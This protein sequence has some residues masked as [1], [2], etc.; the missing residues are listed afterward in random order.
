MLSALIRFSV[1]R[2]WV[3]LMG[4]LVLLGYGA[5]R[6]SA[7][8]LDIFPEFS[9]R[10]VVVQTEAPGYAAE[11]VE[12]LVTAPI[13][14]SLRG[15]IGLDHVRSESIQGLSIV[16][17]VFDDGTSN[18]TNR[19]QVSERLAAVRDLLPVGVVDPVPVPLSSSSATVRTV[20]VRAPDMDPIALRRIVEKTLV[21]RFMA[22]RGVA[23]VNVFGGAEQA[24]EISPD[25]A[26]MARMGVGLNGVMAAAQAA[27]TRAGA[28]FL[29]G[30]NQRFTLLTDGAALSPAALAA[31]VVRA[32][33]RGI[34]TLGDVADVSYA[35]L[36]GF[37]AA[38]I[39]GEPGI[40]MMIIGQFGAN[41]YTVSGRLERVLDDLGP[42]L[43]AQGVDLFPSLFVP[44]RYIERSL[45]D[46]TSH[47]GIGA[48]M[49]LVV[50]FLGLYNVRTALISAVAIPLSLTAALLILVESGVNLNVMVLAG[51]AIALGEVVDDAVID[52]E[53]IFRRLR[54]RAAGTDARAVVTGASLE[55]RSSVVYA[56]FIVAL[57]F[58]PLLTL[59]GVSGRLFAPL[60]SAYILSVLASL[61]VAVT[62][63]PALCMLLLTRT[64]LRSTEA[65]FFRFINPP[66]E[67][68]LS[69]L[70]RHAR[71]T[72]LATV[73]ISLVIAGL[74][75]LFGERFL[76]ELREGH[77]ILH[78]TGL[79]GTSIEESIRVGTQ[80]TRAVAQIDGVVSVSQ[81]AGRA[82]RG[83][84]TY[85]S[86]YSEYD[87]ALA[88]LG[89]PEQQA[90]LD[91]IIGILASLPGVTFEANTFLTERVDETI[92]GYSAPVVVNIFGDDLDILDRV[93]AE[94]AAV[95]RTTPG[96]TNVRVRS[97]HGRPVFEVRFDYGALARYGISSGD[98]RQALQALYGG[99]QVGEV[100]QDGRTY[101]VMV[102]AARDDRV[103]PELLAQ[104]PLTTAAGD[105]V[106][107][108][109]IAEVVPGAGRYN[110][111]HRD[112][113]RLQVVT[114]GVADGDVAGFVARLKA[115][116]LADVAL[117]AGVVTE[118]TGAATEQ[119]GARN[120]LIL[121]SLV[122]GSAV[123]LLIFM[124]VGSA[125]HVGIIMLN[126]PFSFVGGVLAVALTGG[127]ISIGSVVGFVTL[128]GIT[129]RNS[130]MLVSHYS[131]LVEVD[132][133][134][135]NLETAVLGA[136][137][138]LPAILMTA[139][140]TALAMLPL[141]VNS[142]NPGREIMG[143]MAG[144][145][146][147]GLASSTLLNLFV[148]PVVFARYGRFTAPSDR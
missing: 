138:R 135:W 42:I 112:A 25:L 125:R 63:T 117:P 74:V 148:M 36:P 106:P 10:L 56:T 91:Q 67:R 95:A 118:F 30:P 23:D 57:V 40:I 100:V 22:V 124:A 39:G 16:T 122:A 116:V 126:L 140:V 120:Q 68:A 26:A 29:E 143:P 110:I 47:L 142:D 93:A 53:N 77:Y 3:V 50:L 131:H 137:E 89:G 107:L 104:M 73:A 55:V 37:S 20:G 15:L 133:R 24:L 105:V 78:T 75:P 64:R 81:W 8:G 109:A 97:V 102:L 28:G 54:Q 101:P 49:V 94:V 84:D 5:A 70:M 83:A 65:P 121:D 139:L 18:Y 38:Q 128:F 2:P 17:A 80:L 134:P 111:V 4:A 7:A 13:E 52:T 127:V 136:R 82:E 144:I 33:P 32:D 123:L 69:G 6:I 43:A 99:A 45:R 145:I 41:T 58:V 35:A 132:G 88:P 113:Q 90:V 98:A 71:T 61:G 103:D 96:A 108:G 86:H 1:D 62:V 60:G 34:V 92:S 130:I 31:T 119:A 27:T 14:R 46:I 48:S 114:M 87:V 76:P 12:V 147:G 115:A 9:P 11:Q 51:L 129:V 21:P 141:T 19:A 66:F 146:I 85:G 44:A 79:P 59:G 72:I